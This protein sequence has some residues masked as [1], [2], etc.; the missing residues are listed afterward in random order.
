MVFSVW[1]PDGIGS[2]A[3]LPSR[4][5]RLQVETLHLRTIFSLV[6]SLMFLQFNS[7]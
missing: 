1:P 3:L 7:G 6:N 4:A 5:P 2:W